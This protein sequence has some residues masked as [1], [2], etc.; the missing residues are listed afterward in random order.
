VG[1][2]APKRFLWPGSVEVRLVGSSSRKDR[3]KAIWQLVWREKELCWKSKKARQ[4]LLSRIFWQEK[5]KSFQ[6]VFLF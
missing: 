5:K 6:R 3:F 2:N 1:L 4:L